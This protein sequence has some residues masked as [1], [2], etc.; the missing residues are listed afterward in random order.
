MR[1]LY[2]GALEQPTTQLIKLRHLNPIVFVTSSFYWLIRLDS[3]NVAL[4]RLYGP[5]VVEGTYM[6]VMSISQVVDSKA[7]NLPKGHARHDSP[8]LAK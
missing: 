6:R 3:D 8:G 2:I 4:E 1:V 7:S 5:L